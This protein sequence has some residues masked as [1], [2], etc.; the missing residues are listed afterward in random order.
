MLVLP[1]GFSASH[2]SKLTN[3]TPFAMVALAG[4]SAGGSWCQCGSSG[5]IC[6]PGEGIGNS[7]TNPSERADGSSDQDAT[8]S[9]DVPGGL[10]L[11]TGALMILALLFTAWIKVRA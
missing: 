11:G 1:I 5:C 10:E 9:A 4:H 8:P 7:A 2:S 6:D 3:S